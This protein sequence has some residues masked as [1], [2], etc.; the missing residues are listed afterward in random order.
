VQCAREKRN[1]NNE[2]AAPGHGLATHDNQCDIDAMDAHPLA[3]QPLARRAVAMARWEKRGVQDTP[4]RV[5]VPIDCTPHT[6]LH[7]A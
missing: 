2:G 6:R 5:V 1:T 7:F 3:T 4:T